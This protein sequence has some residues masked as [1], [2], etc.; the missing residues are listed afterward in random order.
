[1]PPRKLKTRLSHIENMAMGKVSREYAT[2]VKSLVIL[3]VVLPVYPQILLIVVSCCF[4]RL[5]RRC[6]RGRGAQRRRSLW[7]HLLKITRGVCGYTGK[8]NCLS[9]RHFFFL[10]DTKF[11]HSKRDFIN[12]IKIH[13]H[14]I[15]C[16]IFKVLLTSN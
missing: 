16:R 2:L 3:Q 9:Q 8:S 5:L 1:M 10:F 6:D 7:I 4:Y 13:S 14:L 11:T 15:N 12:I